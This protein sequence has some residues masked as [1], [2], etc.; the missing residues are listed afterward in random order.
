[1][2]ILIKKNSIP[3][4]FSLLMSI[5]IMSSPLRSGDALQF[6][7]DI[8][9]F[10]YHYLSFAIFRYKNWSSR[11]L[12]ESITA[13]FSVH[14]IQ[15]LLLMFCLSFLFMYAIIQL[16]GFN[17]S[18]YHQYKIIIA[19]LAL[20]FF[21]IN[22][23]FEG[24]GIIATM[25]N[26]YVP[27]CLMAYVLLIFKQVSKTYILQLL[28]FLFAIQQ[29]QFALLGLI[30][31]SVAIGYQIYHKL[32]AVKY[33]PFFVLS[34]GGILSAKLSPGNAIRNAVETRVRFPEFQ[35]I[36]LLRK[37]DM[38]FIKMSYDLLF[39]G[40]V[41][42]F[43]ILMLISILILSIVRKK[44]HQSI[45]LSTIILIIVL[46]YLQLWTPASKIKIIYDTF[47]KDTKGNVLS[48]TGQ[49]IVTTF[50]DL[51]LL[52]LFIGIMLMTWTVLTTYRDRI[53]VFTL[54]IGGVATKMLLS[55]SPTIYISG[56]RTFIP[57]IF[58]SFLITIYFIKL[59]L[60]QI[61]PQHEQIER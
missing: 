8:K 52:I 31:F 51:T 32:S 26:Y 57:M 37:L 25:A 61:I 56:I 59:M 35:S 49:S 34:I 4:M 13:Y 11:F 28:A 47:P 46:P 10:N 44:H 54:L 53:I 24:A 58:T 55:L 45:G 22:L 42:L 39:N 16:I 2:K 23:L 19:I 5:Y 27:M 9:S 33:I 1:M 12:I 7:S 40:L 41:S 17:D 29:E 3:F 30:I 48:A 60:D 18:R 43:F 15:F 21:P 38:G 14:N 6:K 20:F 50:P 36:S